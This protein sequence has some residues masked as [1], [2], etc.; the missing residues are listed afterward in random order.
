MKVFYASAESLD[1]PGIWRAAFVVATDAEEAV[2]L[3]KTDQGFADYAMPPAELM[4][5]GEGRETIRQTVGNRPIIGVPSEKG[6]Y[7][8]EQPELFGR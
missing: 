8:I 3:L 1:T 7:P 2:R 6:V 5:C 4:E